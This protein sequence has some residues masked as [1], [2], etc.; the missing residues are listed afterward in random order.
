[1]VMWDDAVLA[2]YSLACRRRCH[3]RLELSVGRVL[4]LCHGRAVVRRRSIT[5]WSSLHLEHSL[6]TSLDTFSRTNIIVQSV[7]AEKNYPYLKHGNVMCT[8]VYSVKYFHAV[9]GRTISDSTLTLKKK[10]N[11]SHKVSTH[12]CRRV[13]FV[14]VVSQ[15]SRVWDGENKLRLE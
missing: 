5:W 14:P 8:T 2:L 9:C 13:A 6:D 1:M 4:A 11:L 15:L 12:P 10:K 3:S 7:Y